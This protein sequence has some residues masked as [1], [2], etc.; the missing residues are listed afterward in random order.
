IQWRPGPALA[1]DGAQPRDRARTLRGPQPA[2][3]LKIGDLVAALDGLALLELVRAGDELH[4]VVVAGGRCHRLELGSSTEAGREVRLLLFSLT[5]AMLRGG[6]LQPAL[7][8]LLRRFR[9]VLRR[10]GERELVI[11][12]VGDLHALP[13]AALTDRPFTVVPSA[14]AWLGAQCV[15]RSHGPV[16]LVPGPGLAHADAEIEALSAVYPDA[17][18]TTRPALAG[19]RLVHFAT[20]GTFC[21]E[22]ALQSSLALADGPLTGYDLD[23]LRPVPPTVV[24]SACD[25]GRGTGALGLA[26]VLLSIGART[27]IAPVTPVRDADSPAFMHALHTALAQGTPPAQALAGLPRPPGVLG[28]QSFGA[29]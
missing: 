26:S 9:Q 11:A 3:A 25:A 15:R 24:L 2:A 21:P 7:D 8:P 23:A 6:S 28:F 29:G 22:D 16:L 1:S 5:Q 4:A 19:A 12:P 27:V 18:I 17:E 13:W 10:A 20:H 14:A